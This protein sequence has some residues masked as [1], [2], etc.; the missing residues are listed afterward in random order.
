IGEIAFA[1]A[2]SVFKP[3][4]EEDVIQT[5]DEITSHLVGFGY[6]DDS[7]PKAIFG[8]LISIGLLKWRDG[9]TWE[10]GEIF[11]DEQEMA[12]LRLWR[13]GQ[14]GRKNLEAAS[15]EIRKLPFWKRLF[16]KT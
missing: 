16:G 14:A 2:G 12:R 8:T 10:G 13:S 11:I 15:E 4:P 9:E 1:C 6:L 7:S 3:Q 5:I